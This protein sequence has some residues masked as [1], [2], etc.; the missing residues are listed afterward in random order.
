MKEYQTE[1]ENFWAGEFGNQY[2]NRNEGKAILASKIGNFA[3]ILN[4]I[5]GGDIRT[6]VEF[7]SN[8]GLNLR[9]LT[10]LL[11]ELKATA[12]EINERA[13][14][15]C[16]KIP[17]VS[18]VN[19]SIYNFSSDEQYDLTFTSGVL[20]HINPDKLVEVYDKLYN[21]SKRYILIS[22][23]YNP[24]PVEVN[25]RGNTDKLFKRDFAGE[26]MDRFSDVNL[27]NY[28]FVYHRDKQFPYDDSTWFLMEKS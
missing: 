25:Y 13:A 1:Q 9:A 12:V 21:N 16:G 19:D 24:T 17:N 8:I 10:L 22:E 23:Y 14:A 3:K 11:P 2:I 5:P 26:F 27:I 7:G 18:V 15:I 4:C 28:G 6:C 20:I